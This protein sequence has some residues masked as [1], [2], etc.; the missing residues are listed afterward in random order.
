[1]TTRPT[2]QCYSTDIL[3]IV[4]CGLGS[5]THALIDAALSAL[6]ALL[7]VLDYS[8][9]KNELFPVIANVFAHTNSLAIK[10]RGLEAINT[11]CGGNDD[12][13]QA[14][15]DGLDGLALEQKNPKS[16]SSVLDKYTVQEKVVPLVKG[17]K[18]KEPG[19]MVRSLVYIR[20]ALM[21]TQEKIAALKVLRQVGKVADTD[22]LA[23]EVLP[24][25]WTFAL[26]PLLNLEQF[27]AFMSLIKSLSAR[28]EQEQTRKLQDLGS[29]NG[30]TSSQGSRQAIRGV[31]SVATGADS[32]GGEVDFESLVTG[33][34]LKNGTPDIMDDW[35][36]PARRPS[37]SRTISTQQ[38]GQTP[39]N[40]AWSSSSPARASNA[41]SL[42]P[43]ANHTPTTLAQAASMRTVTPDQSLHGPFAALTPASPYSQPL[44]PSNLN[45]S[46]ASLNNAT[47][48]PTSLA[49][50]TAI[51]WSAAANNAASSTWAAQRPTGNA[52][53]SPP[54]PPLNM[55][56]SFA[57]PPPPIAPVS[58]STRPNFPATTNIL[59]RQTSAAN[60][61]QGTANVQTQGLDKYQSLL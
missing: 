26:G 27:Q 24:I 44:K 51:N 2:H 36:A 3:P 7:P 33:R 10:I 49:T 17:I 50:G 19:V 15:G 61:T 1:M 52:L 54:A 4:A 39:P 5:Q 56:M 9:I 14:S 28:V 37:N 11:L 29:N 40:Y 21:L 58:S 47:A 12:L 57:L 35:A 48:S 42:Q 8:T 53:S 16:S 38:N 59:P 43:A 13:D 55:A 60:T 41:A 23:L 46:M 6:P 32:G 45:S 31:A 34:S 20:G 18:T 25:L 30:V 22:F